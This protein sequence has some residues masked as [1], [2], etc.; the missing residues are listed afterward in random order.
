MLLGTA[1]Y[2]APEQVRGEAVDASGSVRAGRDRLRDGH[3]KARLRRRARSTRCTR[4]C[5]TLRRRPDA[6]GDTPPEFASIVIRLLQESGRSLPV[7]RPLRTALDDLTRSP[8]ALA[9]PAPMVMAAFTFRRPVRGGDAR[10]GRA[11]GGRSGGRVARPPGA[12]YG[13]PADTI[14]VDPSGG[15]DARFATGRFPG[16]PSHRVRRAGQLRSAATDGP[17]AR[18]LNASAIPGT[19]GAK[20]PFWSPRVMQIGFFARGKLMKVGL[21]GGV[22]IELADAPD[23]RGGT[24]NSNGTIVFAPDLIE[25]ALFQVPEWRNGRPVTEVDYARRDNAHR[26]PVF[27]PDGLHF[28]YF[29]RSEDRTRRGVYVGRADRLDSSRESASQVGIGSD[30]RSAGLVR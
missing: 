16:R 18:D 4:S 28:L 12:G 29:L 19:E 23:G 24:W 15:H 5:T 13:H 3:R 17:R 2:L 22:P 20:Q 30:L 27:L 7:R 6:F 21:T 26:W 8:G 14:R 1:G 10:C 25:T 11:R 9:P